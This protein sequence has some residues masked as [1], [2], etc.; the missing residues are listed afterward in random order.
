MSLKKV[1]GTL[2]LSPDGAAKKANRA[3]LRIDECVGLGTVEHMAGRGDIDRAGF[4]LDRQQ[5]FHYEDH[6]MPADGV[7]CRLIAFTGLQSPFPQFD[8]AASVDAPSQNSLA[9][10]LTTPADP[11]DL[12]TAL[13]HGVRDQFG[14]R[15]MQ[16]NADPVERGRAD[17]GRAVLYSP[18]HPQADPRSVCQALLAK[19]HSGAEPPY[20]SSDMSKEGWCNLTRQNIASIE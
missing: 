9:T 11:I 3:L 20:I 8:L 10:F 7:G 18:D 17:A 4:E 6:H 2:I 19:P 13:N 12:R 14:Q 16:R 1:L 15:G 5:S